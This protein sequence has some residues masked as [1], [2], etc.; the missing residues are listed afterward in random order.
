MMKRTLGGVVAGVGVLC[1]A[2]AVWAL[3][4]DGAKSTTPAQPAAAA[5]PASGAA[6]K[7]DGTKKEAKVS[8]ELTIDAAGAAMLKQ[9]LGT[10]DCQITFWFQPG[11]EPVKTTAVMTSKLTLDG[12]VREDRIENASFGPAMNNKT[13]STASFSVYNP[14]TKQIEVARMSSTLPT[15]MMARGGKNADGNLEVKC[16]YVLMG[17][18][19]TNR[20]V[21]TQIG[22]GEQKVESYMSFNGSP[23]FKGMEMVMK[24]RK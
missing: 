2:G 24:L 16:E 6:A 9:D 7:S 18:K 13:W 1:V 4:D 23:E 10:W 3:G 17:M 19:A 8:S 12:N 11:A 22:A 5:T 20:D 15:I 21:T 14:S